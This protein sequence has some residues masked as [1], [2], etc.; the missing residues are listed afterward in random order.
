[1]W[2]Q[3]PIRI[4]VV[5]DDE[6]D[7]VLLKEYISD[8][9]NYNFST[10]WISGYTDA[11]NAVGRQ[12]YDL[13]FFDYLLGANTGLELLQKVADQ[14]TGPVIFLTG[15]GDRNTD[16]KAMEF[17]AADYLVKTEIDG[18]KLERSIRYALDGWHNLR[19][20]KESEERYRSIFERSR[21]M[22][23]I[24]DR[25]GKF[26]TVNE[27]AS[28]IFGYSR[29]EFLN[30]QAAEL[31]LNPEDR[32]QYL[33]AINR[34]GVVSNF[35]VAL[36]DKFNNV[37][38]CIISGSLQ[39]MGDDSQ[40]FYHGIIHDITRRKKIE[41]DLLIAEKLAVTGRIVRTLA[42][43]VRNPLTNINLAVEQLEEEIPDNSLAILTEII[44]RNGRRINDLISELL[45]S[46]RP[47]EV[48]P[49]IISV[50]KLLE[51]TVGLAN[52]RILLKGIRVKRNF[53]ANDHQVSVDLPKMRMALLNIIINAI[54]AMPDS[55]GELVLTSTLEEDGR[56]T[57]SIKDNG[58]GIPKDDL[59]R[60][61]E[62]YFTAKAN[63]VGLGLATTHNII[64]S[65]GGSIDVES[66]PGKGTNFVISLKV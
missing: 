14:L 13:Y 51:E 63:G 41:M 40:I 6:D 61:F 17:G 5:E 28:R 49:E 23:Y 53:E 30:L 43:E 1:M 55:N 19:A 60:L 64:K 66:E 56:V 25:T 8:I 15:K 21:D 36:K 34:T 9:R 22:I 16:M 29:E 47:A 58:S 18:E 54:E 7:Y 27:S 33:E 10:E 38:Y 26:L 2:Q 3:R 37:R 42:H 24:T 59:S 11:V 46:S 35:E 48:H 44:K 62:P 4:L 57:I 12:Q 31:Y 45:Q 52:D 20:L 50:K 39:M 65:H 32:R